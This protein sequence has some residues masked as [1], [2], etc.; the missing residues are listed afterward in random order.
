[1]RDVHQTFAWVVVGANAFVGVWCLAAHRV[2]VLRVR[3]LWWFVIAAE[4]TVFAQVVMGVA[5]MNG[6]GGAPVKASNFHMLYGFSGLFAV[7]ILYSY[8]SQ[9]AHLRYLLYGGG[10]LFIMGLALRAIT[11][12][13][14]A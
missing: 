10:S 13:A 9:L 2:E 1:M 4:L 7:G 14:R 11:I 5:V 8:R 6:V 12:H 3:A